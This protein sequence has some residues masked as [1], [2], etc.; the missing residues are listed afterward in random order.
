[1]YCNKALVVFEIMRSLLTSKIIV[2]IA[3]Y[4]CLC[5]IFFYFIVI[6]CNFISS[7]PQNLASYVL[8]VAGS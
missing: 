1:M 8:C 6:N 7:S 5:D 3:I 2:I 4:T